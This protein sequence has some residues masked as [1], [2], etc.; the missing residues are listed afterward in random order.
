MQSYDKKAYYPKLLTW[1]KLQMPDILSLCWQFFFTKT[2]PFAISAAI[3][4]YL[5][6]LFM[7]KQ[8]LRHIIVFLL[9]VSGCSA[10]MAQRRNEGLLNRPYADL[11]PIHF[12]FSVG[13]HVQDL[14]IFNNGFIT[15]EG[16][17]WF[18]EIPAYSPGFCVNVLADL[19]IS[20]HFNLRC[21]PGMYFGNKRI[22]YI[23]HSTGDKNTQDIKSNYIVVPLDLKFSALR[24]KNI[25]PYIV[26]GVMGVL[27]V[28]KKRPEQLKLKEAD[29]MLTIGI[30]CDFYL[31]FFKLCP[32]L[33][34]CFGLRNLLD[35]ERP[36]LQD[37]PEMM[38][39][40]QSVSRIKSN[41]IAL[42]FYFE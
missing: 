25:R 21:S 6:I 29:A 8:L 35:S 27:D 28:S 13:L 36:D 31:P 18:T 5:T 33:K 26:G 12:G 40:T 11:K 37:N 10:A 7:K 4:R 41:M 14:N 32:E 3:L 16:E 2:F 19:R 39:Y 20:R 30:G 23:N 1:V 9:I 24:Y 42:T 34:F 15:P 22:H 17:A 38:K